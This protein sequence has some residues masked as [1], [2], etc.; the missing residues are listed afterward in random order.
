MI[1]EPST[2]KWV[3]ESGFN[4]IAVNMPGTTMS[5]IDLWCKAGSFFEGPGEEGLAHFLEHMVFKGSSELKEGEFD[6]KIESLGGISN[7]ATGYDEVHYYVVIPCDQLL[8]AL[9]LLGNLIFNPLLEKQS[10]DLEKKV[11]L[12]EIAQ[13]N[14]NPE[15]IIFQ[16]L[17]ENCWQKQPYGRPIL[18]ISHSINQIT[19]KQMK[20]FHN[21]YYTADNIT[22]SIAGN[23]PINIEELIDSSDFTN[24]INGL[25]NKPLSQFTNDHKFHPGREE[26][27]VSRLQ[28]SRIN[29][30][31][32]LVPALNQKMVIGAELLCALLAEGRQ[33]RLVKKL[34][35]ELRLVESIEVDITTLEKGGLIILEASCSEKDI[36]KVEQEI[37][38][39]IIDLSQGLIDDSELIKAK[40]IVSNS[41]RFNIE[42]PSQ[43]SSINGYNTLWERSQKLLY[44]L[45]LINEWNAT[46]L[47]KT[48]L[49]ELVQNNRFTL[50]ANPK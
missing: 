7:A 2:K 38:K 12:E 46:E 14:D 29:I 21:R 6:L 30:A 27:K 42:K 11:V 3:H 17:L 40:K 43:V 39:V 34:R 22:L 8:K 31:W 25:K 16:R 9:N 10:F 23:L 28:L 45:E 20:S 47:Q 1:E 33:S 32:P 35:E 44:P 5:A 13:H 18:G 41:L 26:I 19:I 50:I 24:K 49:K 48:L 15:E 37:N 4:C 36:D